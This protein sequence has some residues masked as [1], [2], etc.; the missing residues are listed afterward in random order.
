MGQRALLHGDFWPGNLLWRDGRLVAVI[1]WE[2][3]KIG[4]PLEDLAISR[5]DVCFIFGRNALHHFTETYLAHN[6]INTDSLPLWDLQAANRML[7]GLPDWADG[8]SDLGRPDLTADFMRQEAL[9]LAKQA[10]SQKTV[11]TINETLRTAF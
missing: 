9:W 6:P 10:I 8:W 7:H 2:D 11:S 1:D 3:A 5:L 4:D